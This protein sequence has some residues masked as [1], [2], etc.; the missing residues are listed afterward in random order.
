MKKN[1]FIIGVAEALG[2]NGEG[3][4]RA[5]GVTLFV[6]YLLP[7]EKA[8][9][10]ILKSKGN[11]GYGK[12]DELFT[13]AEERVRPVCEVFERCGGCQL[14]HVS[15][16]TQ[17]KFKSVA[18]Q[19]SLRKIGGIDYPVPLCVPS[20]KQLHYR[21]KLQ[22]P[23]GKQN[24]ENVIGFYAERSHRIIPIKCCPIHPEWSEKLIAALYNFMEKC[25]IDG[26]D[27]ESGEGLR[28]IVVR[29][30]EGRFLVTLVSTM[31]EIK[32]IDY[33]LYL[34]DGIFSE[35]SFYLNINRTRSNVI[36]G[37]EF[38]LLKGEGFYECSDCGVIFEAGASTFVQV[39]EG[40]RK[41]L[42]EKALSLVDVGA[43]DVV[44]DCYA[45]GGMLTAMFAKRCAHAYGIE[46]VPEA[47]ACADSLKVKNNLA[48][49]MTNICGRVEDKL[50]D[51]LQK[52]PKAAVVLD[53]P[54]A[55]VDRSVLKEILAQ[56]IE[57]LIMISCNPATLARDLG[58]LTG[59]LCEN[60][61]GELV[62]SGNANGDYEIAYLQPFD[63]FPQTK[64]VETLVVLSHKKPD[65]HININV[66]FG[67][68]EGQ[69]SLKDIEKRALERAPKKKTT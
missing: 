13:P 25:G 14:Q 41:K 46:I 37:E 10:K 20:D 35:Y 24:G 62:K 57:K 8:S 47:S 34:L 65:G 17:L 39:N 1:Q 64:H 11:I 6:P 53:P 42:Y 55:G 50:A 48:D 12:V 63:M 9:I 7:G 60:E 43:G 4:V 58:V 30:L 18:V 15:Y 36:F 49:K 66:E 32:G 40:V 38:V 44:I 59:T 33:L 23:I 54:R 16:H 2:S 3:I 21:N 61:R 68:E 31:R 29:E 27:E 56:K 45:G 28:H 5:D 69:V 22:L 51:I 26:Y 67:E 19:E 52:H